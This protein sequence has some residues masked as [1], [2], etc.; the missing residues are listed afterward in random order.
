[1]AVFGIAGAVVHFSVLF[2][3]TARIPV[4]LAGEEGELALVWRLAAFVVSRSS[5]ISLTH[6]SLADV[7][8]S[9][10]AGAPSMEES[11]DL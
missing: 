5:I 6:F 9:S 7:T 8:V 2:G 3:S 1:M 11:L 4:E 10:V